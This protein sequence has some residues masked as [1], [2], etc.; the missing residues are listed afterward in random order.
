MTDVGVRV[1]LVFRV[2]NGSF[3]RAGWMRVLPGE[4]ASMQLDRE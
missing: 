4:S 1:A 3:I 2:F